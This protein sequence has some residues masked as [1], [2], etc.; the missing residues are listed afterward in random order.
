MK[1]CSSEMLGLAIRM[2]DNPAWVGRG[3]K[4]IAEKNSKYLHQS[5][6]TSENAVKGIETP[7]T[8]SDCVLP[9]WSG[10]R[11]DSESIAP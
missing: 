10:C 5:S 4:T 8:N 11:V 3:E 1:C 6:S 7:V 2:L 9:E